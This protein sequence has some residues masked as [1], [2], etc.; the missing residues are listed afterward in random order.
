MPGL[1][2]TEE[3]EAALASLRTLA[4]EQGRDPSGSMRAWFVERAVANLRLV[5]CCSPLGDTLRTYLR[6]CPALAT[7]VTID[8]SAPV[9][10]TH[11][12]LPTTPYV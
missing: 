3:M 5:V 1:H 8:W 10:Y 11:L 2:A 6:V 7:A 12:T 9:S 4:S